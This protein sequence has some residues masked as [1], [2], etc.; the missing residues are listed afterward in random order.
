M[1]KVLPIHR[2][3]R[4]GVH[5]NRALRSIW[6]YS[7][8]IGEMVETFYIVCCNLFILAGKTSLARVV[9][10]HL[11]LNRCASS[12]RLQHGIVVLT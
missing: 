11:S 10:M 4:V 9:A 7:K 2:V 3:S 6:V 12:T 1:P 5:E 8:H